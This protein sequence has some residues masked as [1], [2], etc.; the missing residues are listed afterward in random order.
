MSFLYTPAPFHP[1][2]S[3]GALPRQLFH[4]G[5]LDATAVVRVEERTL[6]VG[7]I[8][9]KIDFCESQTKCVF[10]ASMLQERRN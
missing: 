8:H 1:L 4:S 6:A 2:P 9:K 7:G 10:G 3:P 5:S